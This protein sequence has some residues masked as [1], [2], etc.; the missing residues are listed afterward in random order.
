[1][2]ICALFVGL[3]DVVRS[4]RS[5]HHHVRGSALDVRAAVGSRSAKPAFARGRTTST[6]RATG[7]TQAP[8]ARLWAQRRAPGIW[9]E[10]LVLP[11]RD[12]AGFGRDSCSV[13]GWSVATGCPYSGHASFRHS[14]PWGG[15]DNA[16]LAGCPQSGQSGGAVMATNLVVG[17]G[18]TA[19]LARVDR[20]RC[21]GVQGPGSVS[22]PRR[23][24]DPR[25]EPGAGLRV[26]QAAVPRRLRCPK[27]PALS[28]PGCAQNT[29]HMVRARH[30]DSLTLAA[31]ELPR[32]LSNCC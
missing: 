2:P 26:R 21:G 12:Q 7:L 6:L 27:R 31:C 4:R 30:V 10:P 22:A 32:D 19:A 17:V 25:Q 15:P 28:R 24:D 13:D 3:D 18:W 23:D 20:P 29:R 1:M 14:K 9:P 11:R 5:V 8:S 16:V